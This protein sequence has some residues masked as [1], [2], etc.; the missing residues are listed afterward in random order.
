MMNIF[1][2][3]ARTKIAEY[4][5]K[6]GE[7]HITAAEK[8]FFDAAECAPISDIDALKKLLSETLALTTSQ[9][10]GFAEE[11]FGARC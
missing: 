3:E 7:D 4:L 2:P 11:I 5:R 8:G 1:T 9:C 6:C 10:D